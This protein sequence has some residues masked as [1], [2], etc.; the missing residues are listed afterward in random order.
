QD[1][2]KNYN[3]QE[4]ILVIDELLGIDFKNAVL[5]TENSD[6]TLSYNKKSVAKI[7]ESKATKSLIEFQHNK[8]KKRLID[9]QNNIYLEKLGVINSDGVTV[10]S[11]VGKLR[12]IHKFIETLSCS[13]QQ[14]SFI[15]KDSVSVTDMGSGKGYLTFAVY[16]YIKNILGKNVCVNGIEYRKDLVEICNDIA[17]ECCF[18]DLS[19]IEG[20]IQDSQLIDNDIL[21]ALH[22]CDTA[23]DDAIHKGI[24][25]ESELIILSPCCHKQIRK[26]ITSSEGLESVIQHGIFKERQAEMITDT[27]RGL[28][29]EL[30]GYKTKIFE[31]ISDEHTHKNIMIVG[32]K[33]NN[34]IKT[35]EITKK[36]QDL[37]NMFGIDNVYLENLL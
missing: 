25:S 10:N 20:T 29:M 23:T 3:N 19:F 37:K 4:A 12:Q 31:Y 11:K 34:K 18:D 16:D 17:L 27:L 24:T 13:I 5:F 21:I 36:I 6:I 2:T 15:N 9:T 33:H 22:A 26:E 35:E 28:I 14:S 1:I 7:T 32:I 8:V 30:H